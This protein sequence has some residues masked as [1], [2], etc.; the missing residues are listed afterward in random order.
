MK[1]GSRKITPWN[2]TKYGFFAKKMYVQHGKKKKMHDAKNRVYMRKNCIFVPISKWSTC[3][4]SLE[5]GNASEGAYCKIVN[6]V[7]DKSFLHEKLKTWD[8]HIY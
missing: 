8:Q 3:E 2:S 4:N 5:G 7:T 6:I 1:I